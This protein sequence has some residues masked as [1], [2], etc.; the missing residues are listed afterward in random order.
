MNFFKKR[1]K[2]VAAFLLVNFLGQVAAPSVSYALTA[3]PTA[4]EFSSFE[5]VDTTDMVNLAT[6][7]FVY[8]TP[9]LE[10]PGPEGGYP[11]SLSYHAGI[12]L[13]QEA[14]WVGLGWTLNP[15]AINRTVDG[16]ADDNAGAKREVRDYWG[17]GTQKT[18][19]YSIGLTVPNSGIGINYSLAKTSDTY[20]GFSANSY[21]G[22]SQSLNSSPDNLMGKIQQKFLSD[23][24]SNG[25]LGFSMSS[26][27]STTGSIG[28]LSLIAKAINNSSGNL[29][30]F[31]RKTGE[32][33][34]PMVAGGSVAIKEFYTRYWSDETQAL[35]DF[36]TLYP[37]LANAKIGSDFYTETASSEFNTYAFDIYDVFSGAAGL[38]FNELDDADPAKQAGGTL[39]AYDRFDVLGQGIGGTLQP[40]IFEN[41]D[42]FGQSIYTRN[43]NS[44]QPAK[45][46]PIL[47]YKSLKPFS[48]KKVDF[49]FVND[50]SNALTIDPS[51]LKENNNQLYV[52]PHTINAIEE[53]FNNT[54]QNQKLAGSRHVEWFTNE[55]IVTG[56]ATQKGFM[57]FYK[58][59]SD[60]KLSMDVF[61]NYLQPEASAPY[62]G[63]VEYGKGF[64]AF[65]TDKYQDTDLYKDLPQPKFRSLKPKSINLRKKIGGFMI[66]NESGVTYHYAL[67]VYN[68]NE[69]T[70]SKLKKTKKNTPTFREY[71]NDEPYAYTWLLT[72]VT[73]PDYVDKDGNGVLSDGDTGYW[74]NFDY[75]CWADAYQWRT[76]QT[77]YMTDV[78]NE[79]ETFSYGIKELYYLDAVET[80]THKAIFIKSKRKDGKGVT[81]RLEG[82]SNPRTYKMHYKTSATGSE[83]AK[84]IFSISPVS[85]MKLDAVYLFDKKTLGELTLTKDKGEKYNQASTDNP[86]TYGYDGDNPY[87][88]TIP[89]K[90]EKVTIKKGD[91]FV[92]VKYHNGDKVY[93]DDDIR[94]ISSFKEK[95]LRIIEFNTDYSLAQ[96][97][98]NCFGYAS[99]IRNINGAFTC[100]NLQ[101]CVPENDFDFEWPSSISTDCT[102]PFRGNLNLPFC[103]N[104]DYV[105]DSEAFYSDSFLGRVGYTN[106]VG[107]GCPEGESDYTGDLVNYLHLGKLTLMSVKFL[108][109][110]GADLLPPTLFTYS[111][112]NPNYEQGKYDDWGYYKSDFEIAVEGYTRKTSPES[113]N[114]LKAW[115]LQS[116][117]SPVGAKII[118]DYEP[119][120]YGRSVYNDFSVFSID[121]IEAHTVDGQSKISFKEKGINLSKWFTN[122]SE[123]KVNAFIVSH[124]SSQIQLSEQI[125]TGNSS[126]RVTEIGSDYI[127][128]TSN[129]LRTA[130]TPSDGFQPYLIS[131]FI[132][133]SDTNADK[134]AGGV[135]VK[136]IALVGDN[137]SNLTDYTYNSPSSNN[138]SGVT[139]FKPYTMP[140]VQY[141]VEWTFLD[142][143]EARSKDSDKSASYREG[144]RNQLKDLTISRNSFLKLMSESIRDLLIYTREAPS[145]GAIYEY[146]TV[147]KSTN[148]IAHDNYTIHHF[149]VFASDMISRYAASYVPVPAISAVPST[150]T[151]TNNAT[152]IASILDVKTYNS[153]NAPINTIKYGYLYDDKDEDF[154][155]SIQNKKQGII[156]QSF[157]KYIT[158]RV[159]KVDAESNGSVDVL[160]GNGNQNPS[161]YTTYS[162]DMVV[163]TTRKDRSNVLTSIEETDH[164]KGLVSRKENHAFDF[165]SGQ[166]IKELSTESYGHK[167]ISETLP[168]YAVKDAEG[169]NVYAGMGLK[170]F[171]LKN[172]HMLAQSAAS[173][174]YI[175][176]DVLQPVGLLSTAIQTWSDE[177]SILGQ[178][179]PQLNIWRKYSSYQWNGQQAIN[180]DGSYPVGEWLTPAPAN[181]LYLPFNWRNL[182]LNTNWEKMGSITLYDVFSH[183]LEAE[184]IN[185]N[186][187]STRMDPKQ[188]RV[189][190]GATNAAYKEMA[191][192]GTEYSMGNS[193]AEGGVD[194][195]AGSPTVVT[196][197]T[198]DYSL[199][200]NTNTI[201]YNYLLE[202]DGDKPMKKYKASVWLYVP[203]E[204]ES[205]TELN[206]VQLY[207]S[208]HGDIQKEVHATS[209]KNKSKSWYLLELDIIPQG[210][211]VITV[212]VRNLAN[213]GAYFDDFR[214]HPLDA[215]MTSY[216]YDQVT[217]ELSDV[218]DGNNFYTHYQYD[219]MGRLIRTT[220][221]LLNFDFGPGKESFRADQVLKEA[222]YNNGK[223][224]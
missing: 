72:S 168:A 106:H 163:I 64:G 100:V 194:R 83:F 39:P 148:G 173:Y 140:T 23:I 204:G 22:A 28:D 198:G 81:S 26:K 214:V 104:D 41:G 147:R 133:S 125:Y 20:K 54:N 217:G 53:G 21:T 55:E 48:N 92:Y 197:H 1:K 170:I 69:Y 181:Q 63:I 120:V 36:G 45:S 141:P 128:V 65:T 150:V 10:I 73:G 95:A 169:A 3:G 206:K 176:N 117:E 42:L 195:G 182:S 9:L 199:L 211:E 213:R 196:A 178:T 202:P 86:H 18:K 34:A 35:F 31:T 27:G 124:N 89:F 84:V 129:Q 46:Y 215:G 109:K 164:K 33:T 88:Y 101:N 96:G 113:A 166:V 29:T 40:Y 78:E 107:A 160:L 174:S 209:Q 205:Q 208:V 105:L 132:Q 30:S 183:A 76:P 85:T 127:I 51:E 165:Y 14:S 171:D 68:Y 16:Y 145:P 155:L 15:G 25:T 156:Q 58:N 137:E 149:K 122:N 59:R 118:V 218:L 94:L 11:L 184:D 98:P 24:L 186:F 158:L 13:D 43:I 47:G 8:N 222:K 180:E 50:F 44:G 97:V 216:V 7:D 151:L 200:V 102:D 192:S 123:I 177:V 223:A 38:A 221:E 19:T 130:I 161:A 134:F 114:G 99:D 203:G 167:V 49:R 219:A 187:A 62:S 207:Y 4:P 119:R 191:Y 135:R 126:D 67:P 66:T 82:G 110:G 152:D 142:E 5:P 220:R 91:D 162:Q 12:K 138:S 143:I 87:S 179:T 52:D 103:C 37:G 139:S 121:A 32:T 210:Q 201:G 6:G 157:Q 111:D 115:S 188:E 90:N 136:S 57:D 2:V 146:V 212:G 116:I 193:V 172:K 159:Y 190:A 74:V 108:G 79:Y 70:R 75:G 93:D 185:G 224:Q 56:S 80:R 154:E 175:A 77:G 17:G 71:K 112:L 131:G 60:R 189:I 153:S 61:E 144:F